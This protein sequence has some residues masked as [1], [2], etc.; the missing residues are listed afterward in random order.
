MYHMLL[1]STTP[2]HMLTGGSSSLKTGGVP[3]DDVM[4][5]SILPPLAW[6]GIQ[7][8]LGLHH[9]IEHSSA[10][11]EGF[12]VR[13]SDLFA[14]LYRTDLR[15]PGALPLSFTRLYSR[16]QFGPLERLLPHVA[17]GH[18]PTRAD[19]TPLFTP[20]GTHH[21]R[22]AFCFA[23]SR[24]GEGF[25]LNR[26]DGTEWVFEDRFGRLEQDGGTV[27][28]PEHFAELSRQ[29]DLLI[30]TLWQPLEPP[31]QHSPLYRPPSHH[32]GGPLR[33]VFRVRGAS[34][35]LPLQ[36]IETAS[37]AIQCMRDR[38]G[39]LLELRQ[40][41][42]KRRVVLERRDDGQLSALRVA[43]PNEEPRPWAKYFYDS[44]GQLTAVEGPDG[45][46]HL[47]E[48]DALNRLIAETTPGGVT[49]RLALDAQGRTLMLESPEGSHRTLFEGGGTGTA[50]PG[51]SPSHTTVTNA[52]GQQSLFHCD[53]EGRLLTWVSPGGARRSYQYDSHGR[54]FTQEDGL[55]RVESFHWSP[56][57]DL[58]EHRLA[59][60][61]SVRWEYLQHRVITA[62]YP[63]GN[64]SSWTYHDK[65]LLLSYQNRRHKTELS[66][67]S[68]SLLT[69]IR[70]VELDA[71]IPPEKGVV[72]VQ[73]STDQ[74]LRIREVHLEGSR[75]RIELDGLGNLLKLWD[76]E[77]LRLQ[78]TRDTAGRLIDLEQ[79][80]SGPERTSHQRWTLDPSGN[81]VQFQDVSGA[82]WKYQFQHDG[83]CIETLSP[84]RY[85]Q[86]W[87]YDP[88][89]QPVSHTNPVGEETSLQWAADGR[90]ASQ[91]L[92][93]N[94]EEMFQYDV[95]GQLKRWT[96]PGGA[97]LR[98]RWD[99]AGHLLERQ[100]PHAHLERFEYD[101]AGRLT[102]AR[103]PTLS[104]LF[105]YDSLGHRR[106]ERQA[107]I[108]KLQVLR[109]FD[110]AA[111]T[112]HIRFEGEHA[113]LLA[114]RS[115]EYDALGRVTALRAGEL[116]LE[117]REYDGLG[118]L[119]KRT[120]LNQAVERRK[121]GADRRLMS[122]EIAHA[123]DARAILWAQAYRWN[124]SGQLIHVHERRCPALGAPQPPAT[125]GKLS[126]VEREWHL[127]YNRV[128]KLV[129]LT[130][131]R[132]GET[133]TEQWVYDGAGF[134]ERSAAGVRVYGTGHVLQSC[135]DVRFQTDTAGRRLSRQQGDSV[136][137]THFNALNQLVRIEH[138]EGEVFY[139]TDA[140]GRL[141]KRVEVSG[142]R[143]GAKSRLTHC[144]WDGPHLLATLEESPAERSPAG[145][146]P[147]TSSAPVVEQWLD[148]EGLA[149]VCQSGTWRALVTGPQRM[150]LAL[151]GFLPP[152]PPAAS[153]SGCWLEGVGRA[154]PG[155]A[156]Q[157]EGSPPPARWRSDWL[158][159]APSGLC[160]TPEGCLDPALDVLVSP[161]LLP[162]APRTAD[163]SALTSVGSSALCPE[164]LEPRVPQH[165]LASEGDR[166]W[167]GFSV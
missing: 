87:R 111:R 25:A 106:V 69:R 31:S 4:L 109:A 94:L 72:E 58:L 102:L 126:L 125:G 75:W 104:N 74:D 149:W 118:K 144:V 142:T 117:T 62:Q 56:T 43:G 165:F 5:Q 96:R 153:P 18:R 90:L 81:P 27:L 16:A 39:R 41:P 97:T 11:P 33:L 160:F 150:P 55:G 34:E 3:R 64:R 92:P 112:L 6:N 151:L 15:L 59:D 38:T 35:H 93:A 49:S 17:L 137:R 2:H 131:V 46:R 134:L 129:T 12:S 95:E 71:S 42:E 114:P 108:P 124:A 10:A 156:L 139:H 141:A 77:G 105:T 115:L 57:G 32:P 116:L 20:Q 8:A 21:W 166:L 110:S 132:G 60:E 85:R 45:T 89:N 78:C 98:F 128:G 113:G 19:S 70:V 163:V 86:R 162:P 1:Y 76:P 101:P 63:D 130:H 47:Y 164:G 65:G 122:I 161:T 13:L 14:Q 7:H 28:N 44:S 143:P 79:P 29:G 61:S 40:F 145:T 121:Y 119:C 140:L 127:Q 82:V 83:Q 148:A 68:T 54:P 100:L 23:L 147:T 53:A 9:S 158:Y 73:L 24:D 22:T 157:W 36:A 37:G 67:D 50:Q 146:A 107:S 66:Y 88:L 138:A 167:P 154:L 155:S 103:T 48:Y 51:G 99:S 52:I 135:G 91:K 152:V 80:T 123:N 120:L 30:V 136:V 159:D 26:P 133:Q 84:L